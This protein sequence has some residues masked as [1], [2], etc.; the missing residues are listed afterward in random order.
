MGRIAKSIILSCSLLLAFNAAEAQKMDTVYIIDFYDIKYGA[1]PWSKE[2]KHFVN[3]GTTIQFNNS[4]EIFLKAG[5]RDTK[6]KYRE[7]GVWS[8]YHIRIQSLRLI[9]PENTSIPINVKSEKIVSSRVIKLDT[10]LVFNADII[11]KPYM[12]IGYILKTHTFFNFMLQFVLTNRDFA[13]KNYY[14]RPKVR[15]AILKSV[16][17]EYDW[18]KGELRTIK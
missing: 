9:L 4:I 12:F 6:L 8:S 11:S 17:Y 2:S 5:Y 3:N 18:I 1:P 7:E 14:Q 15:K 10:I 16:K 13:W